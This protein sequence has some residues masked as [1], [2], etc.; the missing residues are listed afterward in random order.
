MRNILIGPI[1]ILASLSLYSF[2]KDRIFLDKATGPSKEHSQVHSNAIF[3]RIRSDFIHLVQHL[4]HPPEGLRV[5]TLNDTLA[6]DFAHKGMKPI[7]SITDVRCVSSET[8]AMLEGTISWTE[9][10][11]ETLLKVST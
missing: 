6:P 10:V 8:G 2:L 1:F 11:V 5:L 3:V 7:K 9:R 4:C